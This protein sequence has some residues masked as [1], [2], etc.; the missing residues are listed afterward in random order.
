MFLGYFFKNAK[1]G[2]INHADVLTFN[3]T[4][5]LESWGKYSDDVEENG[6]ETFATK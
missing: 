2:K 5:H 1:I 6:E 4:A 3:W